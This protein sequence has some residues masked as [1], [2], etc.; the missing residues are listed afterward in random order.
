VSTLPDDPS[1]Y[2]GDVHLNFP[3]NDSLLIHEQASL[4]E[5]MERLEVCQIGF[6]IFA[7]DQSKCVTGVLTR[8]D[9]IRFLIKEKS[10]SSFE[11]ARSMVK[12]AMTHRFGDDLNP[13][14]LYIDDDE[15]SR[16]WYEQL[17]QL[18]EKNR[19]RWNRI[20]LLPVLNADGHLV[21]V[22]DLE[23][24]RTRARLETLVMA[25]A[26]PFAPSLSIANHS[27][28]ERRLA[29]DSIHYKTQ[30]K[31]VAGLCDLLLTQTG[32]QDLM[33]EAIFN[34]ARADEILL[35]LQR[36][37]EWL[38]GHVS[39]ADM[40]AEDRDELL[41]KVAQARDQLASRYFD[42][43]RRKYFPE[44]CD[45]DVFRR[46]QLIVVLGCRNQSLLRERV[47]AAWVMMKEMESTSNPFL[48]LSGGGDGH[49][50]SEAQRMLKLLSEECETH[51]GS[52]LIVN[53]T[54]TGGVLMLKPKVNG[55]QVLLEEDSRDTLGN[56]VFSWF[57]LQLHNCPYGLRAGDPNKLE[58]MVL[59]TDSLHAPRSYDIFRRVFAFRPHSAQ[60]SAPRIAVR[61]VKRAMSADDRH[62]SQESLRSESRVN[63]ETFRLVNLLTNGYDV[64]ENGHV[65][66]ILGQ[67][68]RL[69]E[70]YK[71][72]WDL[73]RKYQQCWNTPND[74]E[75][76]LNQ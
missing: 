31:K 36:S 50:L 72:R 61:T 48:V 71:G 2:P 29:F 25:K 23:S 16:P 67:M 58:R 10:K 55:I 27:M 26:F 18:R 68:L 5:A 56:A 40:T 42:T 22:L 74:S 6:T 46:P 8:G 53:Q 47:S 34:N 57:T 4:Y 30:R 21:N 54:K 11:L 43:G 13:T 14:M 65:R 66:S 33:L 45:A 15:D 70:Y 19:K 37:E 73:V 75:E 32:G 69:H 60:T 7:M 3:S 63:A 52:T 20:K 9:V 64:I 49:E 76:P 41:K 44:G 62:K 38:K 1:H 12:D 59:V 24:P 35:S 28:E 51:S 17:T 39:D